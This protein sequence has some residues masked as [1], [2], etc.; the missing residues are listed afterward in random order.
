MG[1]LA[2]CDIR[3]K[4]NTQMD[5]YFSMSLSDLPL[6][7]YNIVTEWNTDGRRH[8][9]KTA[10]YI[11]QMTF[12]SMIGARFKW[13]CTETRKHI[14]IKMYKYA[15]LYLAAS[16]YLTNLIF[17]TVLFITCAYHSFNLSSNRQNLKYK[18]ANASSYFSRFLKLRS[19]SWVRPMT[20]QRFWNST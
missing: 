13:H 20:I 14:H 4:F 12:S 7:S 18:T 11:E 8:R 3:M 2:Q 10:A 19:R 17:N 5:N 16:L 9:R 15:T 1:Y 6:N